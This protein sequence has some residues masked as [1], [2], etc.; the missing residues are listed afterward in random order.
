MFNYSE[1]FI[2]GC[3]VL[4]LL[5]LLLKANLCESKFLGM[6]DGAEQFLLGDFV[7]ALLS[8][9]C[10]LGKALSVILDFTHITEA[11]QPRQ[12]EIAKEELFST[13][14]HAKKFGLAQIGLE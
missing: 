1:K 12:Y 9:L 6:L 3:L 4:S 8:S 11:T 10:D 7:L 2:F 13:I 5:L 14:E